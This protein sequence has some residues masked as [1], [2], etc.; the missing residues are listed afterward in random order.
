[1]REESWLLNHLGLFLPPTT[2]KL[3]VNYKYHQIPSFYHATPQ[4]MRLRHA[5]RPAIWTRGAMPCHPPKVVAI[6]H[7]FL[8]KI[9]PPTHWFTL[10]PNFLVISH[11][12]LVV[13]SPLQPAMHATG[14]LYSLPSLQFL[15]WLSG[16]LNQFKLCLAYAH[17][18][19]RLKISLW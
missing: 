5:C 11:A 9:S 13:E 8:R 10:C 3:S 16:L 19:P 7:Q 17:V 1:M 12:R 18:E 15:S 6:A 2:A 4:R 14:A